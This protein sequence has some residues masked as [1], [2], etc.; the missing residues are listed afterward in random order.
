MLHV[1]AGLHRAAEELLGFDEDVNAADD[2]QD[3]GE[4]NVDELPLAEHRLDAGQE[5]ALK[6]MY[7]G[8]IIDA[9]EAR[10]ILGSATRE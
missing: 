6:L 4:W 3:D 1:L 8:R 2:G 10:V 9:T 7:T 5:H